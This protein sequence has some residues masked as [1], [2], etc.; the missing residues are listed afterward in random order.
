MNK[1]KLSYLLDGFADSISEGELSVNGL[2]SDSR[3][4]ESGQLFVAVKGED[5]DGHQY[6]SDAVAQGAVAILAEHDVDDVSVPLIIVP[7]LRAK[8]GPIAARFYGNPSKKLS[9]IGVT[10]TNGK[11]SVAYFIAQALIQAEQQCAVIGTLGSGFVGALDSNQLTTPGAIQ[12]Q[13][14]LSSLA[15][16]GAQAVAM[17]VSSHG[18]SQH[19]VAG[20]DFDIA[21]FTNLSREHLDYHKNMNEYWLAKRK[22]FDWTSLKAAIIN[23]DDEHGLLLAN[24]I[25][26]KLDVYT[27]SLSDKTVE[28]CDALTVTR[29]IQNNKG[30]QARIKTPW[31]EGDLVC[32][33]LGNFNIANVL[34]VLATMSLHNISFDLSLRILKRLDTVPGRMQ[35]IR[36]SKHPLVVVDYSHTP[37]A[38]EQALQA[39]RPHVQGKLWCVFGC[40]GNRDPGKRALMGQN[41]ERYSDQ[42]IITNDNPRNEDPEQIVADIT[43]GLLCSWA[44]EIEL[45]RGAAI[46]HAIDCAEP[47]DIVLIAGKGHEQYQQVGDE[48]IPFNDVEQVRAHIGLTRKR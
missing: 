47:G 12:L 22:L 10:G 11:S 8:L 26:S 16:S 28:G 19:R 38:I 13:Q 43:E 45:D 20:V 18:L 37:D 34:A 17:E 7:D 1:M 30:F 31:G 32:P 48:K 14:Q 2:S 39:L 21:I 42:L 23:I 24:E 6:I 44:A 41:A 46:A 25:K 5:V 15:S 9:T 29:I 27:I 4:I 33:F 3:T 35:V 40:G 36:M